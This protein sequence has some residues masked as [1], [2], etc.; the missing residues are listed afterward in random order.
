LQQLNKLLPWQC[1]TVDMQNR[2]FGNS[3]WKG[4]RNTPQ[5]I[6]DN[7][8][9]LMDKKF[10]LKGK[11]V[12]EVGCFE[13]IH[14]IGLCKTGAIVD[15]V[16]VRMTNV[17]KTIVRTN[18]FGV[19][20]RV[21]WTNIEDS[22]SLSCFDFVHHVG[23]LYHLKDPVRHL[24]ALA[25]ITKKGLML[26]THYC[27]PE[28]TDKS[29]VVGNITY[30]YAH[31]KES[32]EEDVF[33]GAYDHAKWLTLDSIESILLSSGFNKVEIEHVRKERNGDRCLLFAY[34]TEGQP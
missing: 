18:M 6:P 26:D 9:L 14:T 11:T 7:R 25:K 22:S 1:F 27:Q 10:Q 21:Y 34:K 13:G 8:I 29:Y 20:P 23:V 30:N 19:Y 24:L 28:Q 5:C 32:G 15:A 3:A 4:K 31:Y 2:C 33:S 16:D 12:L 17:V